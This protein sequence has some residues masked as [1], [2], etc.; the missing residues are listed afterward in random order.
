ML[1]VMLCFAGV[2]SF[3]AMKVQ[4]F[5][6]IDLPTVTVSASWIPRCATGAMPV[7]RGCSS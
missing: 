3:N 1:F 5:P 7:C 4:Q 6:D 2:L